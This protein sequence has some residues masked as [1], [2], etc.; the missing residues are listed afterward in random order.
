MSG[1][2][3][4]F[5]ECSWSDCHSTLTPAL[6]YCCSL[7]GYNA[8]QCGR[9]LPRFQRNLKIKVKVTLRLAVYRKSSRFGVKPL[10]T[11]N[12]DLFF[13]MNP[14]VISPYVTSSLTRRWDSFLRI[15][16]AFRQVYISHI[17]K[18]FPFALRTSPLS[19]QALLE[20]PPASTL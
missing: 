8:V 1:Q 11:Y 7:V 13:Q 18:I 17:L 6:S 16:L 10:G 12:R 2:N 3:L 4:H 9:R 14:C 15:C 19:V 5:D 20:E